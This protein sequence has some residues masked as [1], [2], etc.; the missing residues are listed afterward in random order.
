MPL[1]E[2]KRQLRERWPRDIA[3]DL[4]IRLVEIMET[5]PAEQ[6]RLLTFSSI[7]RLLKKPGVD[8]NTLRALAILAGSTLHVLDTLFVFKDA[9]YEKWDLDKHDIEVARDTGFFAHPL[10]GDPVEDF[11]GKVFPY[12]AA[13]DDFLRL[14]NDMND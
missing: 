12:F 5:L 4:C 10:T 14:K 13:S 1:D 2:L 8:E 3:T 6:L 9:D 11:E 7:N